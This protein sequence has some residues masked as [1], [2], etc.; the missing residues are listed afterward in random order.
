MSELVEFYI[1]KKIRELNKGVE[2]AMVST[3]GIGQKDFRQEVTEL[4]N[5]RWSF[6][7]M[8]NEQAFGSLFKVFKRNR[9]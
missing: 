5:T 2:Y 6:C 9:T 8:G 7:F 1:N 3:E 4:E